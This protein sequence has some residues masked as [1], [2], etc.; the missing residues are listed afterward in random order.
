MKPIFIIAL[1][2][3][4]G[5]HPSNSDCEKIAEHMID[6]FTAP[7]TVAAEDPRN[8]RDVQQATETWRRALKEG[9]DPTR[10]ILREVCATEMG[11]G[12]TS[13]ILA[14]SDEVA[15]AKCFGG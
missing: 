3:A 11:S 5:G 4:C 9:R 6:V 13:C 15:L 8:G 1:M 14:A 7:S 2:T 12:A 10:G